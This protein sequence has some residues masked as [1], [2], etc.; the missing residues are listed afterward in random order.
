LMSIDYSPWACSQF[1]GVFNNVGA[2]MRAVSMPY[3][4]LVK[5]GFTE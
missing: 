2:R 4:T 5:Q 3:L 1:T